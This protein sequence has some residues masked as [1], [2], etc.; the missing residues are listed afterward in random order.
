MD[1]TGTTPTRS[2][3]LTNIGKLGSS[4][5]GVSA[6]A[7]SSTGERVRDSKNKDHDLLLVEICT[8]CCYT[9]TY[10]TE[11]EGGGGGKEH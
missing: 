8:T 10:V 7:K 9:C 2:A 11:R 6:A 4:F 1:S 5:G 3:K